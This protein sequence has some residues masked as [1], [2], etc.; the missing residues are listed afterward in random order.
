MTKEFLVA[1]GDMFIEAEDKE[2]AR[3]KVR[4]ILSE[5]MPEIDL[6]IENPQ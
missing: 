6:I 2:E 4:K 3:E 5:E 1:F